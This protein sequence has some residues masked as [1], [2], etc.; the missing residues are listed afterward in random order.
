MKLRNLLFSFLLSSFAV[1]DEKK[2]SDDASAGSLGYVNFD[3]SYNILERPD[4]KLT[5]PIEFT[6][7]ETATFNITFQNRE[8]QNVTIVG[9]AGNVIDTM[10]GQEIANVTAQE[11][12]PFA[13]PVNDSVNFQT[14]IQ[15]TLPEGSFY[16]APLLFVVKED[17]L[18]KV[19]IKP[20]S[21]FVSPP[22]MSFFNPGFLSVQ[23]VI[24]LVVIGATYALG[25]F[26][27]SGTKRSKAARR[28]ISDKSVDEGW[29]PDIHKK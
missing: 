1:A 10:G 16:L 29:L 9:L 25:N 7:K 19:G 21:I 28:G 6:A 15:L 5:L 3:V 20:V 22:P 2:L 8:D 24:G 17:E 4:A 23:L 14:A 11:L 13:V 12:G 27:S 18:M 26:R